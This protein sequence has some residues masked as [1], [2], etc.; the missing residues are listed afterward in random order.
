MGVAAQFSE[1][2]LALAPNRP[3]PT[4]RDSRHPKPL[5]YR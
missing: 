1:F 5:T 4:C 2:T 3:K